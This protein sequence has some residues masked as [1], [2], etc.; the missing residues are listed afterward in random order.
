[1]SKY[2]KSKATNPSERRPPNKHA[3]GATG[4]TPS[5]Q[6]QGIKKIHPDFL[7]VISINSGPSIIQIREALTTYCQ[8]EIGSIS[9][10]FTSGR[11]DPPKQIE[12]DYA[13]LS[14]ANDTTG[15]RKQLVLNQHRTR[16]IEIDS[17]QSSKLKLFGIITSM[18]TK[19]LDEKVNDNLPF[20]YFYFC[21]PL[22]SFNYYWRA[23]NF[24]W[25]VN[26]FYRTF[27]LHQGSPVCSGRQSVLF[28]R[29]MIY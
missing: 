27:I 17:Y 18:M 28:R 16:E 29:H 1:M 9:K 21:F 14:I 25:R 24:Y 7:P 6:L 22:N 5:S 2:T 3:F 15:M 4:A 13:E 23:V 10:I 20:N 19:D 26:I 8:R 12:I 11:Y